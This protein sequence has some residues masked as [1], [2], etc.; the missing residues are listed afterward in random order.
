MNNQLLAGLGLAFIG[1][2]ALGAGGG[3]RL[4][5]TRLNEKYNA[6]MEEE[7][8]RT[9]KFYAHINKEGFETPQAAADALGVSG[10]D[11]LINAAEALRSYSGKGHP[12]VQVAPDHITITKDGAVVDLD[13][14]AP[15]EDDGT[16]ML[17]EV[18]GGEVESN[19]FQL[20]EEH[21]DVSG[22][23]SDIPYQLT[24]IEWLANDPEHDQVSI[25]WYVGDNQLADEN[26]QIIPDHRIVGK[27]NLER[28]GTG[29][30][31]NIVLVRNERLRTDYEVLRHDG[32]YEHAVAG[33]AHSD[34]TY[35]RR[36]RRRSADE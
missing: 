4:A 19:I 8:E 27:H 23:T 16:I 3:Y 2:L 33:F 9:K 30:D 10:S 7:I 21:V 24:Q 25:T 34:E 12:V 6:Q 36:P 11:A 31:P 5:V 18:V 20:E 15:D 28:F 22:R 1:G 14:D 26:D 35:E 13:P 17:D 29:R 32:K